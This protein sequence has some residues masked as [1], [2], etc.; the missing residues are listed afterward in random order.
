MV[1]ALYMKQVLQAEQEDRILRAILLPILADAAI[2]RFDVDVPMQDQPRDIA[3]V[4]A[5][6]Q[7]LIEV[8]RQQQQ[9]LLDTQAKLD[10]SQQELQET[11]ERTSDILAQVLERSLK[12]S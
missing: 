6:V 1:G 9:R 7:G 11:R 2:G 8:V 10:Q 5:G 4:L 3:E 12:D